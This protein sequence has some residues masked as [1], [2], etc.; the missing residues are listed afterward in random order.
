MGE[1]HTSMTPVVD[2]GKIV[3]QA[4]T[5]SFFGGVHLTQLMIELL[6]PKI[7]CSTSY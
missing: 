7:S 5:N 1:S 4:R 3:T 6:Q 2:E